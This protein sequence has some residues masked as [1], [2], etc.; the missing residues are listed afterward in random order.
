M[1][2]ITAR[3]DA[4]DSEINEVDKQIWEVRGEK[5]RESEKK[6]QK[7]KKK[8]T[9][10]QAE[11]TTVAASLQ[12]TEVGLTN[13]NSQINRKQVHSEDYINLFSLLERTGRLMLRTY[14]GTVAD[15]P[16]FFLIGLFA[17]IR[18][19]SR[20]HACCFPGFP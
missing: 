17:R 4:V 14:D 15:C 10:L 6:L 20:N 2:E 1:S 8:L 7:L 5:V 3:V 11:L 16:V 19:E 13:K 18:R 12:E 9:A